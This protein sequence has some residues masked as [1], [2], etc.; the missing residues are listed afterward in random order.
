MRLVP[1][2]CQIP[3]NLIFKPNS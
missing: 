1:L 2:G 3:K